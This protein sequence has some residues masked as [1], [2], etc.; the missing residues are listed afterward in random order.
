MALL[1]VMV[2]L[3]GMVDVLTGLQF[4][5]FVETCSTYPL[6]G[7]KTFVF[8]IGKCGLRVT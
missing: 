5:R 3:T 4:N 8:D 6:E 2:P 7:V 1:K